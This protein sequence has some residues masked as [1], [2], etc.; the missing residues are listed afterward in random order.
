MVL[1]VK[2]RK[3]RSV[4]RRKSRSIKRRKSR[5]GKRRKSRS[6]KRRKSKYIDNGLI[7]DKDNIKIELD[8]L[9]L[10]N[11]SVLVDDIHSK[12]IGK[13]LNEEATISWLK[14]KTDI[15]N[16]FNLC[17][18]GCYNIIKELFENIESPESK[19]EIVG[20]ESDIDKLNCYFFII[21]GFD[22]YCFNYLNGEKQIGVEKRYYDLL[23]YLLNINDQKLT[24]PNIISDKETPINICFLNCLKYRKFLNIHD[25][26]IYL[27]PNEFQIDSVSIN[28]NLF[29]KLFVKMKEKKK[30]K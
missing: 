21:D 19:I 23:D 13:K 18:Y 16:F 10:K 9:L 28:R 3:S 25:N 12:I 6:G 11:E 7:N 29:L 14:A 1:A 2:R 4:K 20:L 30:P 22:K 24:S 5:S 15:L 8:F 27:N 26:K 17:L